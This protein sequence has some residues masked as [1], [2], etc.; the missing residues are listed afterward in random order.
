VVQLSL[1]VLEGH[2]LDVLQQNAVLGLHLPHNNRWDKERDIY[3]T[4]KDS[5]GL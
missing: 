2:L 1:E 3:R 5:T 4:L